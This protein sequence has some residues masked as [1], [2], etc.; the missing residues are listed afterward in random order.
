MDRRVEISARDTYCSCKGASDFDSLRFGKKLIFQ[1][2]ELEA[3]HINRSC[4]K[5]VDT[6]SFMR[7]KIDQTKKKMCLDVEI[8]NQQIC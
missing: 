3:D 6:M 1:I 8:N 7:T 4:Y 2:T 5:Y